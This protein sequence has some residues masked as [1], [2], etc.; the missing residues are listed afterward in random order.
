ME[1]K[2]TSTS[3]DSAEVSVVPLE[4]TGTTRRALR[5]EIVRKVGEPKCVLR[6]SVFH[7]RKNRADEWE[8]LEHVKLSTLKAGEGVALHLSSNGTLCL[9]QALQELKVVAE[10]KGIRFGES[11]VVVA[12][13]DRI[14]SVAK[15]DPKP[16]IEALV[17]ANHGSEFWESLAKAQ[18]DVVKRLSYAQL[19][20]ERERALTVFESHLKTED[21]DEAQWETL[22]Y[23]NQWI[24]GYGLRY[25]FLG[26]LKRQASY[27]GRTY[28]GKGEQKGEFLMRTSGV[29]KFTVLVEIKRPDTSFFQERHY[30]SGVP[31]YSNELI[32]AI[33]Q[34]QVNARTWDVE[35]S[36][37]DRDRED[38][39]AKR[40]NTITPRSILIIGSTNQ[41][42]GFDKKNAFELLRGNLRNPDLITFD[43][44][45]ERAK[46]I[47]AQTEQAEISEAEITE[48]DIPF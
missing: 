28:S 20:I 41:L 12:D 43:E 27:G 36:R 14:V 40:V 9:I 44:L 32:E 8:D 6:C 18:P 22:F 34:T 26:M 23:E 16:M 37:R 15:S 25:Q 1:F 45:Y 38:L 48:E 11:E 35:G 4:T 5:A 7:Q 19:H 17:R 10:R 39:A 46:Y 2:I 13:K 24:F 30:R 47:V 42:E 21:W 33:S 29:E 3:P 31:N